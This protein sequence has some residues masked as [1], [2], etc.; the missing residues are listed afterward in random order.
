M[1][2]ETN[3]PIIPENPLELGDTPEA[4]GVKPKDINEIME[5][6]YLAYAM[7]VIVSRA[8]PDVR[9]GLKPVQRRILYAML[10]LGLRPNAGYKK[11]ARVVGDV[12]GKYHPHGD[13][14]VYEAMVRMA[15][16]FSTR[17]E[18][19]D[20]QGNFGS[21]DGDGPAAYRY[22]EARMGKMAEELL[23]N[24]DKDTVDYRENFDGTIREPSVL[25]AKVP[26]LLMNGI[27]GIAVGMAT[28]IPPHNLHELLDACIALLQNSE[29]TAE[30]LMEY[31]QGPDFP[32]GGTIYNKKAMLEA[33]STGKGSVYIRAKA[34]VQETDKGKERIVINEIPYQVNKANLVRNIAELVQ[35]KKI[36][37]ISDIRDESNSE[38]MRI[39]VELKREAFGQKILNQLYKMT[40]MQKAFHFNMVALIDR[41]MQPRLLNLSQILLAFLDHRKEVTTRRLEYD[42]QVA[43]DRVHIL[44]GLHK[45]L[46]VIDEIIALI[47]GSKTKE[48]AHAGLMKQYGF[49]EVQAQ[50]ILDMRLQTLAGLERQ[51]IAD[52]LNEKL[53]LI[54]EIEAILADDE[55][56]KTV[57]IDE[58]KDI[59]TRYSAHRKTEVKV[60]SLQGFADEDLIPNHPTVI[61]MTK[62]GYVKRIAPDT[63]RSQKR[64]GKGV[65]GMTT[66]EEDQISHVLI[67]NTHDRILFFTS[68]GRVFRIPAYE[69]PEG[70]RQ[71]KGAYIT[72]LIQMDKEEHVTALF[73]LEKT[74]N[75]KNLFMATD[76]GTVKKT[77]IDDFQNVR[78]SGLIAIKLKP[79]EN[80][81][82][83]EGTTGDNSVVMVTNEGMAIH[84]HEDDV[85]QMGRAAAGVRGIRLKGSDKVRD[86]EIVEDS[87][88]E[89]LMIVTQ[90][91]I[92]KR[93][94]LTDY[95]LQGRGG[96]GI[97]VG[98][99]TKKT[100]N[101]I[102]AQV[103]NPQ[104]VKGCDLFLITAGGQM[105]RM[106][107]NGVKKL[108]RVTQGVTL[109]RMGSGDSISSI[110]IF[111]KSEEKEENKK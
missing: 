82:W 3:G 69:I 66:K 88:T 60:Q 96:S 74:H 71:T 94:P 105:M 17:Y 79:G 43:K 92:G 49:T 102:G 37:G 83:V 10:K 109:M 54:S 33:Y 14:S 27:E 101:L 16:D 30:D 91:G 48:D 7:S 99:I 85:R 24:I 98:N 31:I 65:V 12:I 77:S 36:V 19:V 87:K 28:R 9:D 67:T 42:L 50:A 21:I 29:L 44:E 5:Q 47:R 39:V 93:T 64:G 46:D 73:S 61:T 90:K 80:L 70:S 38:G 23:E 40:E 68:R 15:Q 76:K 84:F 4:G 52:E 57:I 53:K 26:N 63:Y 95:K 107:L 111:E 6:S 20:G 89:Q 2:P 78:R 35:N 106:A 32:T 22:T 11:S 56:L 81:Y 62:G 8:L 13:N 58:F 55:K 59:K 103:I 110:G 104:T 18:L 41:G 1:V 34:E 51:K 108:N 97:K 72:N 100:G 86:V 75:I 25:P 45:A